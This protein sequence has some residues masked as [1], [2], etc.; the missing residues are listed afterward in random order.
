MARRL[1]DRAC[2]ALLL[3]LAAPL[4]AVAALGIRLTSTGPVLYRARRAGR[5][6]RPFTMF[7]LR[8]MH[9]GSGPRGARITSAEDPRVF[10]FGKLLRLAKIDE[11]PQLLNVLRGEMALIGPRPEDPAF[12]E[13][14]YTPLHRET[15]NV[16]PGLAS[17]GSLYNY[18]HGEQILL[19]NDPDGRYL[20]DLLPMKL[21]LDLIYVRRASLG[22][23]I[24]IV[25]RTAVAIVT[26]LAGRRNFPD[27]PEMLGARW[28]LMPPFRVPASGWSDPRDEAYR[29]SP[30]NGSPAADAIRGV[31]AR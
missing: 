1:L 12:V 24:A 28:L 4:L 16:R 27:P 21:A 14:H 30:A 23:D 7:K 15:L 19:G 2:A 5:H 10:P 11:L 17:P 22:Y 3:V 26:R 8:T 6:G 18:T 13:Q 25:C 29:P 20:R 31:P 9:S